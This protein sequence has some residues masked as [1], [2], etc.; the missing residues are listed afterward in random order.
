MHVNKN[1]IDYYKYILNNNYYTS[2]VISIADSG[3]RDEGKVYA[4]VK[5]PLFE[6]RYDTS[7]D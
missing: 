1:G 3:Q 7:R 5:C 4:F 6:I 2:D